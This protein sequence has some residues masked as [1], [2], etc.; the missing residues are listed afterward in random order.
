MPSGVSA[1]VAKEPAKPDLLLI[2]CSL[3][4]PLTNSGRGWSRATS[5]GPSRTGG[6]QCATR[7]RG[8]ELQH[9]TACSIRA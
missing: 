3:R 4:F 1:A 9:V 8:Q 6:L 2:A 5:G 7:R